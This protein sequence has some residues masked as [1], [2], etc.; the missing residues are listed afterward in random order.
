M[1]ATTGPV[2]STAESSMS[3]DAS[4]P[5]TVAPWAASSCSALGREVTR[6]NTACSMAPADARNIAADRGADECSGH[7]TA[8]E[9]KA[10]ALRITAPKFADL[11][12]RRARR[13]ASRIGCRAAIARGGANG[14]LGHGPLV[15]H[16]VRAAIELGAAGEGD[17]H[18]LIAS[19]PRQRLELRMLA[20]F[21]D[22]TLDA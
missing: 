21:D 8:L 9:P 3:A 11:E 14:D 2:R 4:R 5:M 19:K 13:T 7:S 20:F 18:P 10:T 22:D 17:R 15:A 12:S 1:T 16:A 6:H